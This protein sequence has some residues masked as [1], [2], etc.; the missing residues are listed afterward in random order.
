LNMV[1]LA[2][3]V[4]CLVAQANPSNVQHVLVAGR[5]VKRDGELLGQD[6]DRAIGLAQ[7]ASERVLGA[8]T[9]G[10]RPLLGAVP[11]G[12]ADLINSMAAQHLARAWAIDPPA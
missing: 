3:P 7:S 6:L 10:G 9:S 12:F 4:G 1:P 11:E 8:I 5:F 2:D